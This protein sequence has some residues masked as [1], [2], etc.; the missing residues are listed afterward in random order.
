MNSIK[1]K[2]LATMGI[3]IAISIILVVSPLKFPWPAAPYLVYEPGDVPILMGGYIYGPIA[4]II[5]TIITAVIQTLTVS[6]DGL[7]GC[8]M[9]IFA[10]STLVGVSSYIYSKKKNF[11]GAIIGA[12]FGS[13]AMTVMMLILNL[14][15]DP[16]FYNMT[17]DAVIK[18]ILP[19]FLPFN[20]LKSVVNSL[21]FL[22][23]FKSSGRLL[24]KIANNKEL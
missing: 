1:T 20:L 4:G 2:Q 8:L 10:T 3:L 7:Y 21:I 11:T 22:L 13:L 6:K 24:L 17:L 9:H 5:L 12:V 18:L 16:I 19:A 14:I 23:I 15:L